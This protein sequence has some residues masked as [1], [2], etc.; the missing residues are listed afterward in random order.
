MKPGLHSGVPMEQYLAAPAVSASTIDDLETR[1]PYAAWYN[2]WLNP[3]RP[4]LDSTAEQSAGTIAHSILLE[5]HSNM[6]VTIDP[7]DHPAKSG[8]AIPKGWTND[9]IR[10][11]RDAALAQRKI[12]VLISQLAEIEQM[13]DAARAFIDTLKDSEPAIYEAFQPAGGDS[14]LTLVWDD[15]GALCRMRPDR[16]SADRSIIVDYKTGGTTAEPGDW[17]RTQM[18]RMRYYVSAAFYRRGMR[19]HFG[20]V[21]EYVYLVQEQ[22]KPFLCSLVGIDPTGYEIGDRTIGRGLRR[23]KEC[24]RAGTWPAY[25]NRVCYAEFPAYEA[26][27]FENAEVMHGIP[28]AP[29][30]IW[31][32]KE[33]AR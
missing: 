33:M 16:T 24:A 3:K 22:E 6:V 13:V 7:R 14:E 15:D 11:A 30:K 32:K 23:W 9:S 17:G 26:S 12:P 2:S 8:G 5:G 4:A 19:A 21:P 1:C 20:R 29:E 18:I 31:N 25:P 10:G 28:Y 27:R